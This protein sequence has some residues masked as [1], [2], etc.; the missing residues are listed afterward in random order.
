MCNHYNYI[1]IVVIIIF[2]FNTIDKLEH[3]AVESHQR[4]SNIGS[5]VSFFCQLWA[6][7]HDIKAWSRSVL[8][9]FQ[10]G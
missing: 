3:I 8:H 4:N 2:T 10:V 6:E 9:K 5:C 1:T 7:L